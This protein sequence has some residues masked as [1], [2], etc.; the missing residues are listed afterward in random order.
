MTEQNFNN[1]SNLS[2]THPVDQILKN[3]LFTETP[4]EI[5]ENTDSQ[6]VAFKHKLMQKEEQKRGVGNFFCMSQRVRFL[7]ATLGSFLFLAIIFGLFLALPSRTTLAE[8]IVFTLK[9]PFHAVRSFPA[10]DGQGKTLWEVYHQNCKTIEYRNGI[11]VKYHDGEKNWLLDQK[12]PVVRYE[13]IEEMIAQCIGL[14]DIIF[15]SQPKSRKGGK[16]VESLPDSVINGIPVCVWKVTL[17]TRELNDPFQIQKIYVDKKTNRLIQVNY[18]DQDIDDVDGDRDLKEMHSSGVLQFTYDE[19]LPESVFIVELPSAD[20]VRDIASAQDLFLKSPGI[21]IINNSDIQVEIKH[22]LTGPGG[23]L[24]LCEVIRSKNNEDPPYI[25]TFV[26][27]ENGKK[28]DQSTLAISGISPPN[29]ERICWYYYFPEDIE[30]YLAGFNNPNNIN[31]RTFTVNCLEHTRK[32]KVQKEFT[33]QD[34]F[35]EEE[36][37]LKV[38]DVV[39]AS[40]VD[41][42]SSIS[43]SSYDEFLEEISRVA[44]I[45]KTYNWDTF[46]SFSRIEEYFKWLLRYREYTLK[47]GHP[48]KFEKTINTHIRWKLGTPDWP[49]SK[50]Y[51]I[52]IAPTEKIVETH[53]NNQAISYDDLEINLNESSNTVNS[54]NI[55]GIYGEGEN[56]FMVYEAYEGPNGEIILCLSGPENIIKNLLVV[57]YKNKLYSGKSV[58]GTIID[59]EYWK[60]YNSVAECDATLLENSTMDYEGLTLYYTLTKNGNEVKKVIPSTHT[61]EPIQLD[62][63]EMRNCLSKLNI[64]I[65]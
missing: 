3:T 50:L 65:N 25:A 18:W 34:S 37:M 1:H 7:G 32:I 40:G 43:F 36:Y 13:P 10:G 42:P 60:I 61:F 59:G 11:P 30:S 53:N 35:T 52:I 8:V 63:M 29:G 62:E 33:P 26:Y 21:T 12:P 49:K 39:L 24:V 20:K 38:Y 64:D 57:S 44:T 6:F 4:Q 15:E 19:I 5:I 58:A 27:D 9:S 23:E 22:I 17:Y 46:I 41:F 45:H 16:E 2:D 47:N 14:E 55:L 31:A 54:H 28:F 51:S 48:E 56:Q